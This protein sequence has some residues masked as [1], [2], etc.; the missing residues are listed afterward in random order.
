MKIS[1]NFYT[2]WPQGRE[3]DP[4]EKEI[5]LQ[6]IRDNE[7]YKKYWGGR[8]KKFDEFGKNYFPINLGPPQI[9]EK[10]F[11]QD[12]NVKTQVDIRVFLRS[13]FFYCIENIIWVMEI[14][15]VV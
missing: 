15:T 7:F 5:S 4:S 3:A 6:L 11:T 12:N 8:D 10:K 13:F 9:W 14:V 2:D 1:Y